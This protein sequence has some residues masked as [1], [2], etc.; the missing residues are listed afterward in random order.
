MNRRITNLVCLLGLAFIFLALLLTSPSDAEVLHNWF[1]SN[2][3]RRFQNGDIVEYPFN[4]YTSKSATR[5]ESG[6]SWQLTASATASAGCQAVS[7]APGDWNREWN[8]DAQL[9]ATGDLDT[10][11]TE[12]PDGLPA[13][14]AG[15]EKTVTSADGTTTA[16]RKRKAHIVYYRNKTGKQ[17]DQRSLDASTSGGKSETSVSSTDLDADPWAKS[18]LEVRRRINLAEPI[19]GSPF[20][21]ETPDCTS[22][23]NGHT[24]EGAVPPPK[25]RDPVYCRRGDACGDKPGIE[26]KRDAHL[27][28]CPK[29]TYKQGIWSWLLIKLKEDCKGEKWSCHITDPDNNCTRKHLHLRD[30]SKAKAGETVFNGY[31]V[32]AG[33]SVGACGDHLYPSSGSASDHALQAFCSTDTNCI[34]K[35]FYLCQHKTHEYAKSVSLSGSSS[36]SAGGSV[37]IGLSTTTAFSSVYWYVAGPGESGLGSH[38]ETDTGSSSSTTESFT[39]TFGSSD[40]GDYVITAYIYN[41][42]DSSTYEV[43]HTV[44]VSGSSSSDATPNC[45]DCTSD[46]SSPCSCTNS[47][48]CGGTVTDGT[49]NCPDCTSHCSSPCSCSN[50]GTCNGAVYTPPSTPSTPPTPPP[51]PSTP[52]TVVCGGAAWTGCIASV[53]SRTEHKVESCSNCGNHYWTCMSGAVD[54]HTNVLTCKRSGCRM[55]L[56]RCQNGPEACTNERYHWF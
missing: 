36:A 46:C 4:V 40:S 15:V 30:A 9:R 43:T 42:S 31:V 23:G 18:W 2:P 56:T 33:Y 16:R 26:G 55:S 52:T 51:T 44:S 27:I 45:L 8:V 37:T 7:P 25:K 53:S 50:S 17:P 1:E 19:D 49:P 10:Q 6:N 21:S 48:T 39:Y 54:R 20:T 11:K 13:M 47:G 35:N 3:D 41:Y 38:I 5:S 14:E 24:C 12:P 34:S 29:R 22:S 28:D 32:P